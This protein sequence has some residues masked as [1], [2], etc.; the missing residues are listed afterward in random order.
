ML[1]GGQ[2]ASPNCGRGRYMHRRTAH[3]R[4]PDTAE[5]PEAALTDWLDSTRGVGSPERDS[6]MVGCPPAVA[7]AEGIARP[8]C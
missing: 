2:R 7:V 4:R 8:P 5:C 6:C 1:P 3:C